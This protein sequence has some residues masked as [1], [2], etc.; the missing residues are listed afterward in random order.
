MWSESKRNWPATLALLKRRFP[1][2]DQVALQTPP[3]RIE[4]LAHHL[5]QLHDLTPSEAQQACDECF[6][7][8]RR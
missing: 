8:P 3:D 4:D 1:R 2:L 5:A 6:D 7:G